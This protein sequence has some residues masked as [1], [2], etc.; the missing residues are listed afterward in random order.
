MTRRLL[1]AVFAAIAAPT[2][3][4]QDQAFQRELMR[5]QQQS[6][7]FVQQLHQSQQLLKVA[8]GDLE[9]RRGLESR[10]FSERQ[11]LDNASD[12]QLRDV[13]SDLPQELR[14]Y[15]RFKADEER[16]L[17]IAPVE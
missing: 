4:Q 12:Q 14:P 13:S 9:R 10:Q 1:V 6:D 2:W 7:A 5:R 3:A 11:R 16:R 15:E 8:P 17:L